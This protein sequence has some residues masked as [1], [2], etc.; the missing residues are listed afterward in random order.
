[1]L[2]AGLCGF[3]GMLAGGGPWVL[4]FPGGL[5]CLPSGLPLVCSCVGP[6]SCPDPLSCFF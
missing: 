4:V 5:G 1:M 3:W 6:V 2:N